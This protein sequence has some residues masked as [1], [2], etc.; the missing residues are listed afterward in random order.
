MIKTLIISIAAAASLGASSQTGVQTGAQPALQ[1]AAV[2][3]TS[4]QYEIIAGP[5]HWVRKDGP[6]E[7]SIEPNFETLFSIKLGERKAVKIHL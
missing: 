3:A 1:N 5:L 4:L 2:L 6:I 7:F